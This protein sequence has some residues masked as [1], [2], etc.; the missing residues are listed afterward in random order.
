MDAAAFLGGDGFFLVV[1][2][3]V[4]VAVVLV[5]LSRILGNDDDD[6]DVPLDCAVFVAASVLD[7]SSVSEDNC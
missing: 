1:V 4:V 2:V 3:V 7:G 5:T 6:G